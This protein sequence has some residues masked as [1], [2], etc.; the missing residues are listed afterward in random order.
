LSALLTAACHGSEPPPIASPTTGSPASASVQPSSSASASAAAETQDQAK[1]DALAAYLGLL[2]AFEH[3]GQVGDPASP[4]L[5]KYATGSVVN[6]LTTAL[7]RQKKDGILG[8]GQTVH[9]AVVTSV[10]PPD[11]PKSAQ[12]NDCMDTRKTSLY[13]PDGRPVPQ[14]KGGFRLTLADLQRVDGAWKV[15]TLAIREPGSCKP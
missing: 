3:A 13:K 14:D 10:G 1:Q 15:T 2:D 12:V 6:R 7:A 11:A 5:P 9:H 4:E 8:R